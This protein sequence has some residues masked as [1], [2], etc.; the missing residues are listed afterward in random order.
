MQKKYLYIVSIVLITVAVVVLGVRSKKSASVSPEGTIAVSTSFYPLYYF[1]DRIGGEMAHVVNITPAGS[2]PHDFEP[3]P[4]DIVRIEQSALLVL[5]GAHLETWGADIQKNIDTHRTKVVIAGEDLMTQNVVE[6]GESVIDPHT[7]LSP[8]L[9]IAMAD[10]I[11]SGFIAADP[12]HTEVYVANATK[13]KTDLATLDAEYTRGLAQ[14]SSRNIVTSHAAFG[15]LA[16][17]YGLN[18]VAISGVSPEAEPSPKDLASVAEFVKKNGVKYIF[19]ESLISPKLSETI[20]RETGAQTLV[21]DPIEGII[22]EDRAKG[23]DYMA[24][25]R[26]NLSNLQTALECTR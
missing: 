19:F 23:V 1:A 2:E 10:K 14:C 22:P 26:S 15:Y 18:Q 6:D 17:A 13:L 25:M 16:S 4:K 8:K 24:V 20:A 3:T 7:W 9:A 11:L 12:L 5:Q 21:L